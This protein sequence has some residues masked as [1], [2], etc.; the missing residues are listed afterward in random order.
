MQIVSLDNLQEMPESVSLESA[1]TF[2]QARRR[3][4]ESGPAEVCGECRRHKR[5][6]E[7]EGISSSRNGGFGDLSR[8]NVWIIDAC[9]CV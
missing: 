1:C 5:G 8:E 6:R 9:K 4:V 3:V 2:L 7:R